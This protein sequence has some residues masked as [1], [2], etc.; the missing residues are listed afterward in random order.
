MQSSSKCFVWLAC[1]DSTTLWN[2]VVHPTDTVWHLSD[3]AHI[4]WHW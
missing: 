4:I 3:F 1:A 2:V